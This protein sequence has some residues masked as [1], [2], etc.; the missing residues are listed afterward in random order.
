MKTCNNPRLWL[1]I[2]FLGLVSASQIATAQ[3]TFTAGGD[4]EV[5]LGFRK[6]GSAKGG[7]KEVVVD[8]GSITNFL[9]MS[10]GASTSITKFSASQLTDA[11]PGSYGNIQWSA[12]ASTSVDTPWTN[13]IDVFPTATV[14][15]TVPGTN[16]N[17]QTAVPNRNPHSG[18]SVLSQ[19][20]ENVA[21]GAASISSSLATSQGNTNADN[22]FILVEEPI[23]FDGSGNTL[24]DNIGDV[25][26]PTFGDFGGGTLT[27]TVENTTPNSFTAPQRSDLY[28]SCASSSK[29]SGTF[30]DPFTGKTNGACYFVGYFLLNQNGTMSFVRASTAQ[31]PAPVIS[32]TRNGSTSTISFGA[33]NGATY[34]LYYTTAPGLTTPR[35]SWSV[36]SSIVGNGGPTNITDVTA[37]PNRVYTVGVH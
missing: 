7:T 26:D 16:V 13:S 12:F 24:T 1:G 25:S 34:T 36:G 5:F 2:L 35:S 23:T 8:V 22:N 9:T 33:T 31:P 3:T 32:L 20:I 15:Y 21:L 10:A 11:F 14:W 4:G 30:I 28:Q 6:T 37:V 17:T 29:T 18:Q 19:R 27:F